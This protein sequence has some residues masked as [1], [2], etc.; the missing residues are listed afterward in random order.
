MSPSHHSLVDN[1]NL[2]YGVIVFMN[3]IQNYPAYQNDTDIAKQKTSYTEL[4]VNF[5]PDYSKVRL[6]LQT[7]S[8]LNIIKLAR[9]DAQ[10]YDQYIEIIKNDFILISHHRDGYSVFMKRKEYHPERLKAYSDL[11]RHK[12]MSYTL[13]P[14]SPKRKSASVPNRLLVLFA[15]MNGGGGYDSS[16]VVERLFVQYFADVQRSLVKNVYVL[17]IADLNISH[18]SYF[19]NTANYPDYEDQ[20]QSLI[21]ET[22]Y[23]CDIQ[24]ENVV[25]YGGS[26]GG[27][28][29]L[30]HGAI[31]NYKVV[32]GDPIIDSSVYN[33][34]DVHFVKHF[35]EANMTNMIVNHLRGN[36]HKMYICAS[37]AQKFNFE[38]S[39]NLARASSGLINIVDLSND[40]QIKTHPKLLLTPSLNR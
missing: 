33:Q 8:R 20:I 3:T 24:P 7:N 1:N 6:V 35:K 15:H 27:A 12:E 11:R 40:I 4:G 23:K 5:N 13:T 14:P 18:G 28:G 26:K 2:S 25:L 38:T 34:K 17:R 10:A 39:S 32:A 21:K 9:R 22:L 30:L 19:T 36:T 16:N 29:A 37:S 31:G